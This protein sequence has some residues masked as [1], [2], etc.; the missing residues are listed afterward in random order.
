[1]GGAEERDQKGISQTLRIGFILRIG[2]SVARKVS[3]VGIQTGGR[4]ELLRVKLCNPLPQSIA[5]SD[6]IPEYGR[7]KCCRY[8]VP[9]FVSWLS[10]NHNL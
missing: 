1:M 8:F 3:L 6:D 2:R 7:R 10:Q 5:T 9:F 4:L